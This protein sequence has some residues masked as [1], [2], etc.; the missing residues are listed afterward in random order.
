MESIIFCNILLCSN[1]CS[2]FVIT[3]RIQHYQLDEYK[4]EGPYDNTESEVRCR[5]IGENEWA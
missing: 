1:G 4:Y 2:M 3:S 5:K